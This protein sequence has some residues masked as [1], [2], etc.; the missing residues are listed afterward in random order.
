MRVI[1][2]RRI[3]RSVLQKGVTNNNSASQW[4]NRSTL[5]GVVSF[6][7]T[8]LV[9]RLSVA[10]PVLVPLEKAMF[11]L[12]AKY[13]IIYMASFHIIIMESINVSEKL[14]NGTLLVF[15]NCIILVSA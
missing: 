1:A 11:L 13:K 6:M 12:P 7:F 5:K 9:L 2:F 14:F 3:Y 4:L 15:E 10:T 8:L